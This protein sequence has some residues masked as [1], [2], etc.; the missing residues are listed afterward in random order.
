VCRVRAVGGRR[1]GDPMSPNLRAVLAGLLVAAT[2]LVAAETLPVTVEDEPATVR[3]WNRDI[4]VLRATLAGATPA[5]RAARAHTRVLELPPGADPASVR[6]EEAKVGSLEGRAILAGSTVLFFVLPQDLDPIS[7]ETM[8]SAMARVTQNLREVLAARAEQSQTRVVLRELAVAGAATLALVAAL[9]LT[10][11]L[12]R[13]TRRASERLRQRFAQPVMG[14]PLGGYLASLEL[15]AARLATWT[16][17][18]IAVY[19][20]LAF[21][22]RRFP[23]TRPWGEAL[24]TYLL[25]L[26]GEFARATAAAIPGLFAVALIFV[27]ARAVSRTISRVLAR[28]EDGRLVVA[29]LDR[30][31]VKATRWVA[32]T[33]IWLFAIVVSYPYIP[34]SDS[35][36]FKGVSVF[37]GLM[38]TLG[39][40]GFVAHILSGLVVVYSRALR[41]GEIVKVGEVVG[42]VTEIGAFSTR[43]VTMRGEEM[44]IPNSVLVGTSTTNFS[45]LAGAQ[46]PLLTTTV[47]IGYDAPWRQVHGLLELAAARTPGVRKDPAPYVLQRALSDFYVQYELRVRLERTE[48]WFEVQSALHG[49]IQDA[50]NEYGVQIMSPH[51][52]GQPDT[53]V[54]VPKSQWH[55]PPASGPGPSEVSTTVAPGRRTGA[56]EPQKRK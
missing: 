42:R 56:S 37:A 19:V 26:F 44:N 52:L 1:I 50:F 35:V 25:Q 23:Y 15:I 4:V 31:T 46:G 28:I 47:T 14:V 12:R 29:R 7:I 32:L 51:F 11:L 13:W 18:L 55:V 24:A 27:I 17:G 6:A 3:V 9:W 41:T 33:L 49:A 5:E 2:G 30:D 20:W 54:V 22:L 10:G 39:S 53:P 8:D 45:R 48:D 34:G 40:S 16:F 38:L 43:I 36:A 21:V